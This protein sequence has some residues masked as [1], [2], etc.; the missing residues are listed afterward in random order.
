LTKEELTAFRLRPLEGLGPK[1]VGAPDEGLVLHNG[2]DTV[3]YAFLDGVPVAWVP[4]NE[5]QTLV[6]LQ[7]G[8]YWLQ[9]RTFL[10]NAVEPPAIVEVPAHLALPTT[11]DLPDK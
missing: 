6:G 5:D 9:W 2:T 10:G 11:P 7:H 4:P 3:R 1:A 8:R